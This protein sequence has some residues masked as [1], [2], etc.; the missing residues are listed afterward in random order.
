MSK[1]TIKWIKSLYPDGISDIEA[2][3]A[4][5]RLDTFNQFFV[6]VRAWRASLPPGQQIIPK[7]IKCKYRPYRIKEPEE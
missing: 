2:E 4:A 6:D 1:A 7:P 3:L 5:Q